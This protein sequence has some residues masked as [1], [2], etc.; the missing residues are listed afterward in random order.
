MDFKYKPDDFNDEDEEYLRDW[1]IKMYKG[2]ENGDDVNFA[3]YRAQVTDELKCLWKG[4]VLS[5]QKAEEIK[6]YIW[7]LKL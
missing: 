1:L 4:G 7:G 5:R 2:Y 3:I 6:D